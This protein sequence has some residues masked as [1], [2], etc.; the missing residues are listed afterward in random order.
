MPTTA[1][2]PAIDNAAIPG[3]YLTDGEQL[4]RVLGPPEP[5]HGFVAV[6]DCRSLEIYLV[7]TAELLAFDLTAVCNRAAAALG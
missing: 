4:Y 7:Q 5:R 6:E 1:P 3:T 2:P